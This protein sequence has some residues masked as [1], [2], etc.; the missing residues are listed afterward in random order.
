[1]ERIVKSIENKYLLPSLELVQKVFTVP[2]LK[3]GEQNEKDI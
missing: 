3:E 1:M 2:S